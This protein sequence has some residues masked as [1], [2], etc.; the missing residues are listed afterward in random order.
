MNKIKKFLKKMAEPFII[1]Q[2][3]DDGRWVYYRFKLINT[4][5][6]RKQQMYKISKNDMEN[7]SIWSTIGLLAKTPILYLT[8]WTCNI[9]LGLKFGLTY[10]I[11]LLFVLL[12]LFFVKNNE[13]I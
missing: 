2:I 3:L 9:K 4:I 7:F 12:Y 6:G 11:I 1:F 8:E 13:Q 5:F 10:S